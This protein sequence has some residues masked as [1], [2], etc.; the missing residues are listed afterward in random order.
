MMYLYTYITS[1]NTF[2]KTMRIRIIFI[3][4]SL[5]FTPGFSQADSLTLRNIKLK[6]YYTDN[7][8]GKNFSKNEFDLDSI[9]V[10]TNRYEYKIEAESQFPSS[11]LKLKTEYYFKNEII[12]LIRFTEISQGFEKY[13]A[14]KVTEFYYVDGIKVDV[15]IQSFIPAILAEL[16]VP[17]D[18][19][20]TFGYNKNW[21]TDFLLSL[22]KQI[23][24]YATK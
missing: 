13:D 20:K 23:L 1:C 22:S 8:L 21:T 7:D 2:K 4:L 19:D 9:L 10:K 3:L 5:N 18:T 24:E 12:Q 14:K 15:K 6:S 17:I 11:K 16:G